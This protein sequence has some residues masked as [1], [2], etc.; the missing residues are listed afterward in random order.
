M[1][2]RYSLNILSA[3]ESACYEDDEDG[4]SDFLS[5]CESDLLCAE[6]QI[7]VM[8]DSDFRLARVGCSNVPLHSSTFK[9]DVH[10]AHKS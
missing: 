9:A 8:L 3:D 1:P 6:K 10:L 7:L 4:Y 5:A 2:I